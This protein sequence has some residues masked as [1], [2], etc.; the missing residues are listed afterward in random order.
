MPSVSQAYSP[1]PGKRAPTRTSGASW[2]HLGSL[3]IARLLR[4]VQ[5]DPPA[6]SVPPHIH[7]T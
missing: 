1:G 6:P 2:P 7:P 5:L 4:F 3:L